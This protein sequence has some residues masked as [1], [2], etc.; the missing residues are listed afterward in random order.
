[1]CMEVTE[2]LSLNLLIC[3]L[4]PPPPKDSVLPHS[5]CRLGLP[6]AQV[7]QECRNLD[8]PAKISDDACL[9]VMFGELS[10]SAP[11]RMREREPG[12]NPVL[13]SPLSL[14]LWPPRGPSPLLTTVLAASERCCCGE[15][16]FSKMLFGGPRMC[17]S[18]PIPILQ[19]LA[20]ILPLPCTRCGGMT[21][22]LLGTCP[23]PCSSLAA[24]T[25]P[26]LCSCLKGQPASRPLC[27]YR[28]LAANAAFGV[29]RRQR[30]T[31]CLPRAASK[32]TT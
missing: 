4:S 27:N 13:V 26:P 32:L 17:L 15:P 9:S 19:I 21:L 28:E 29:R 10:L 2:I 11:L 30:E 12:L 25:P 31:Q 3:L 20:A 7:D 24:S 18:F 6:S 1:M 23:V 8:F 14:S 5:P 16:T 22:P